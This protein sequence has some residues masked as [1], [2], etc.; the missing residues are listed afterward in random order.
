MVSNTFDHDSS[1]VDTNNELKTIENTQL[2]FLN[3]KFAILLYITSVPLMDMINLVTF[4]NI[5]TKAIF[6]SISAMWRVVKSIVISSNYL[7]KEI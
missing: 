4:P 3:K 5:K 7:N 6:I 1:A 2:L